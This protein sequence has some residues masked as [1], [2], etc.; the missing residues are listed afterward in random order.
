MPDLLIFIQNH[1]MLFLGLAIVLVALV[2]IEFMK[3]RRGNNQ[4]LPQEAIKLIN[5]ENAVVVDIRDGDVF[6][7]GHIINAISLPLSEIQTKHKKLDKFK[8]NPI[9]I[10]CSNGTESLSAVDSLAKLGY[11]TRIISG[12]IRGWKDAEMPLVKGN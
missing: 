10:I 2:T 3:I 11:D 12:G 9:L 1:Q 7:K 8:S 5:H 4:I 6:S